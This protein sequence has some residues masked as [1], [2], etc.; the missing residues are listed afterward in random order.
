[1]FLTTRGSPNAYDKTGNGL[2]NEEDVKLIY[3][4]EVIDRILRPHYWDR[5]KADAI[6][7]QAL[8]NILVDWV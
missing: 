7:S 8:A 4:E 6:S 5:W 3:R 1:M 2:I